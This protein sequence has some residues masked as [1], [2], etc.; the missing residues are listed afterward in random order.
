LDYLEIP[1]H[2][3]WDWWSYSS[4]ALKDDPG[5]FSKGLRTTLGSGRQR[6][7]LDLSSK[8]ASEK[9]RPWHISSQFS[10]FRDFKMLSLR[11]EIVESS[12]RPLALIS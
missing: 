3:S 6:P 1:M 5:I 2:Y 12:A 4:Y 7:M 9:Y 8:S 11:S 10:L